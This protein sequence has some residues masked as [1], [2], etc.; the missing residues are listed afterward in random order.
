MTPHPPLLRR[1]L[2]CYIDDT[3][4]YGQYVLWGIS[5]L[6]FVIMPGDIRQ[7]V[8]ALDEICCGFWL[9]Y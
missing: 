3:K 9:K 2:S 1:V 4:R 5:P 7:G 8:I 6:I